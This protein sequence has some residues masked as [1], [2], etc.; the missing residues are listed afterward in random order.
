MSD[1]LK[2]TYTSP[3]GELTI[4]SRVYAVDMLRGTFLI[5]DDKGYFM[6]VCMSN[7]RVWE[8]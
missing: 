6:R 7:C 8:G 4:V 2:V 5:T 1:D 3:N